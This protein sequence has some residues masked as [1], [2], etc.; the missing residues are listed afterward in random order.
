MWLLPQQYFRLTISHRWNASH[1]FNKQRRNRN[2]YLIIYKEIIN[3]VTIHLY[4][5]TK[6]TELVNMVVMNIKYCLNERHVLRWV[7][8]LSII[9]HLKQ[10]MKLHGKLCLKMMI[11]LWN[12]KLKKNLHFARTLCNNISFRNLGNFTSR[13]I[14]NLYHVAAISS[15]P[16]DRV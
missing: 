14:L 3:V 4:Y 8:I 2:C 10:S 12:T 16:R 6:I 15:L 11:C 1:I 13:Q 5:R 7:A 9:N